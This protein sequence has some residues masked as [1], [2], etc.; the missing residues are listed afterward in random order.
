VPGGKGSRKARPERTGPGAKHWGL[1]Y[2]PGAAAFNG[3]A[4]RTNAKWHAGHNAGAAGVA[5][6]VPALLI[7]GL[8]ETGTA[9]SPGQIWHSTPGSKMTCTMRH[10]RWATPVIPESPAN[11]RPPALSVGIAGYA[12]RPLP[13]A[14]AGV[15]VSLC[16]RRHADRQQRP[17]GGEG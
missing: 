17:Y 13:P 9:R 10:F 1:A 15:I 12:A 2:L 4:H 14:G 3:K 7:G 6:A 8:R 5:T 16:R 11:W